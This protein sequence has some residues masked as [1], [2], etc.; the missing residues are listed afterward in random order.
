MMRRTTL[1]IL[2]TLA[3]GTVL[4]ACTSTSLTFQVCNMYPTIQPGDGITLGSITGPIT[5][6]E[7]V[8]FRLPPLATGHGLAVSRVVA[9]PGERVAF[10]GGKVQIDGRSSVEP[11]LPRGTVTAVPTGSPVF[12][13]ASTA[14]LIPAGTYFVMGDNRQ[15]SEDSRYYGPIGRVNIVE[16][17]TSYSAGPRKKGACPAG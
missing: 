14:L 5:R 1:S 9:L 10:A 4:S 7:I 16:K 11:Y 8:E 6:G 12:P 13:F 15:G 3:V 17:V 2:G